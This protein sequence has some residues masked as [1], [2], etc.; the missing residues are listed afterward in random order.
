MYW[1]R[2]D[3]GQERLARGKELAERAV[4]LR[5]DLAETHVA[6]AQ[7]YYDG[8][9]DYPRA[10]D[11]LATATKIQP[12][13]TT[14]LFL[15]GLVFNHQGRWGEATEVMGKAVE[16]DPRNPIL[17]AGFAASCV[18]ARRYAAA[19]R[20]F[21]LAIALS[22]Q[23]GYSH[24]FRA[25]LQVMWHGD[26]DKAQAIIEEASRVPGLKEELA[27]EW[28][29][30]ALLRRD[31][32]EVLRQIE[33]QEPQVRDDSKEHSALLLSR[34]QA[35]VLMGEGDLARR[36]YEAA[37]VEL[38]KKIAQDP[39][40][41]GLH[42]S[43][44]IAYAGLGRRSDAVRE[45]KLACDLAPAT[46]DAVAALYP[47]DDLARVYTMVGQPSEAIAV[48]DD[49]LSRVGTF[50]PHLLR[51]DP[52]WDPLRSDPRFQALLTKY[53]VRE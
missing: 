18:R 19:D 46:K 17:L 30:V 53:E 48:L 14:A 50:T 1:I 12:S 2:C 52:T 13:N 47:L 6:I 28:Q 45:A 16:L 26:L 37:R 44:G 11:E 24:A 27:G 38:E 35:Q 8:L 22:P 21:G 43:L 42:S 5:P 7:Y 40:D 32:P 41:A 25:E 34:G 29:S 36:S 15:T 20:A 23:W 3:H 51:L 33:K 10:L 39:N 4:E 9:D 31:Y 49:K